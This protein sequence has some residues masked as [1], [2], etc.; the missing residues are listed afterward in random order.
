LN[1]LSGRLATSDGIKV[2]GKIFNVNGTTLRK[3]ETAFI[4]QDD[5]FFSQISVRETLQLAASLRLFNETSQAAINE[6]IQFLA[7][8]KV[9]DNYVGEWG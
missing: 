7:L 5:S 1:A 4:Y 8:D 2:N 6:I 9:A 3:D